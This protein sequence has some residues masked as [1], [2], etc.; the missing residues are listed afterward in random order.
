M[1]GTQIE[2][3]VADDH[4]LVRRSVSEMLANR[5]SLAVVGEAADGGEALALAEELHPDVVI[6]DISMPVMD[7]LEAT[8]RISALGLPVAVLIL[9]LDN[10]AQ[11]I[12]RALQNGARGYVLKR[13]AGQDLVDA[14]RDV[15][16]GEIFLGRG[17]EADGHNGR[18]S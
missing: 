7:G 17:V 9:T 6:M 1:D 8:R 11:S 15:V 4:P 10:N 5:P 13:F 14:V 3:V 16:R 12:R 18:R 2:I